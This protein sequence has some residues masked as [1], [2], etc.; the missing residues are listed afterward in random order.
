MT[1]TTTTTTR[2]LRQLLLL[3][4]PYSHLPLL[5][6]VRL[7]RRGTSLPPSFAFSLRETGATPAPKEPRIDPTV[8][9]SMSMPVK[10]AVVVKEVVPAE[11][12]VPE[13]E[14]PRSGARTTGG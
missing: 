4:P 14:F 12:D 10:K 1:K 9:M 11:Q 13:L 8:S 2:H 3:L 6:S 7:R 5:P